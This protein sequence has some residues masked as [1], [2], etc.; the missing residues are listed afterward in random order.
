MYELNHITPFVYLREL[1][2][3]LL[4]WKLFE[5]RLILDVIQQLRYLLTTNV[6]ETL[7]IA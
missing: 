3:F 5:V 4:W 2:L 6:T 7:P 1:N